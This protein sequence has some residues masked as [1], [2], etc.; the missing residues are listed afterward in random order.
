[1]DDETLSRVFEPYFTT[2]TN[3]TGLGMAMSYKIIKEFNGDISIK[4]AL[5]QGSE[6]KIILP[7]PQ[8]D[9]KLLTFREN[10]QN[11]PHKN[12]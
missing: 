5:G 10:D 2:K 3:G 4:S 7:V 8:V 6:F 12:D 11:K 1:M 9:K